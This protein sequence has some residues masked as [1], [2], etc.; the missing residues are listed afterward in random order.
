MVY[1]HTLEALERGAMVKDYNANSTNLDSRTRRIQGRL[2]QSHHRAARVTDLQRVIS[3]TLRVSPPRCLIHPCQ[4]S[5]YSVTSSQA[6]GGIYEQLS[7]RL[8]DLAPMD[9]TPAQPTPLSRSVT[10]SNHSS[11]KSVTI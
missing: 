4:S 11:S 1:P 7:E 5:T 3:S 6:V 2:L 10:I 9:T 8:G